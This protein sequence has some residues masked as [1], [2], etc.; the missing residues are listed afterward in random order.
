M[1]HVVFTADNHLGKY[2]AKMSP[3]QLRE[4]RKRLREAWKKTVD[5]AIEQKAHFYLHGGDLFDSPNPRTSELVWVARQFRRL[6]E[7]GIDTLVISG[8]HDVPRSS[9]G[10]ATPQRIYGELHA[11]RC[12][13]K[14]TEVEWEIYS[15]NGTT[16]AI[17]GLAPD[18]RL[19]PEDD[20]L[21]E[22][23]IA[24]PEADIVLLMAHYGIEG[25]LPPDVREPQIPKS[26]IASLKGID[27]LLIGHLHDHI[28]MKIGGVT[29][30]TPGP[31]ERMDFGE[32]DAKPGFLSLRLYGKRPVKSEFEHILIEPEPM[33][34]LEI[35]T[36]DL[37]EKEVTEYVLRR[38]KEAS[39]PQQ[40]LQCRIEG[41]LTRDVYR[42]IRFF[43]IWRSGNEWN[44]YFDLDRRGVY[45]QAD[46]AFDGAHVPA[47]VSP[48]REIHA[49]A[50]S[51]LKDVSDEERQLIEEARALIL[52][53]WEGKEME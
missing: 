22:V 7:A 37:P 10:G 40:L 39:R 1:V 46:H 44:A 52:Q 5:Y 41:P 45:V 9:L 17:G 15:V 13:T 34:Q 27:F 18:P 48:V 16:I 32:V 35:R 53:A 42:Q 36:T 50:D 30:C 33:R 8:N 11:A 3:T 49:V 23:R 24:P 14:V 6:H 19:S 38:V 43:D 25:T 47:K 20:P 4:R 29:V 21:K 31:T 2:Y 28:L 51:L 26:R 12:F